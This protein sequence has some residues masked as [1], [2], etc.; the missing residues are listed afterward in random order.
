MCGILGYVSLEEAGLPGNEAFIRALDKLERRGPDDRGFERS[1]PLILGHRRLS[2]ID[3]SEA[4]HQPM[5]DETG[6]YTMVFNGELFNFREIRSELESE[7]ICF[8][9]RSDSEVLLKAYIHYGETCLDKLNGFFAFCIYDRQKN[10]LFLARDRFGI[11]PLYYYRNGNKFAFSSE[12]RPLENLVPSLEID[13]S[14]LR[15]FLQLNY[16]PEPFSIYRNIRK[17]QAGHFMNMH[18]G[19]NSFKENDFEE[20]SWYRIHLPETYAPSAAHYK[21]SCERIRVLLRQ[22]VE[23]RLVSDVPLGCFLSGG[24]DSSIITGLAAKQVSKLHTFSLGFA[25]SG[26]FDETAYAAE[27]AA[28]F[29]TIHTEFK[30]ETA[31]ALSA[32]R[33]LLNHLDEPF[34]DSSALAVFL[35]TKE[36]KKRVTVALSGDGSDELFAGYHKHRAEWMTG[37]MGPGARSM[38]RLASR[39]SKPFSGSRNNPASNAIRQLHRFAEGMNLDWPNRYWRWC[40]IATDSDAAALL[41]PDLAE[42][43]QEETMK[44]IAWLTRHCEGKPDFN[45]NLLNDCSLVLPG[46]ML[47]K[48]DR[49]SMS[50]S[51]EVRLPFLDKTVVEFAFQLPAEYKID[52]RTQKKILK[53]TFMADLPERV[54][55]RTKKGFEIPLKD[56]LDGPLRPVL[57]EVFEAEEFKKS[58]IFNSRQVQ[59]LIASFS[60]KQPGDS[61][62][63]LWALLVFQLWKQKRT[64]EN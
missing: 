7:G 60:K 47:T 64:I 54:L 63:R 58:R 43:T 48:V 17:L 42:S 37:A 39:I 61:A 40:S 30:I 57:Q 31:D 12:I 28:H 1:G 14:S 11:K 5:S 15:L 13:H 18:L 23:R 33:E 41:H 53:D 55:N 8:N 27:V 24:L 6:R 49:M 44:R 59:Q 20:K 9:S 32:L 34:A 21:E 4:G 38:V 45:K 2:I 56:W 19:G 22:A 50:N 29:G 16:I 62:A 36:A 52:R 26:H 46:D 51:L 10:T 3:L 35:L 25:G